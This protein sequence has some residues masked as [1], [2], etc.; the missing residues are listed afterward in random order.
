MKDVF[1]VIKDILIFTKGVLEQMNMY[2]FICLVTNHHGLLILACLGTNKWNF[3]DKL[4]TSTNVYEFN[5][6][7]SIC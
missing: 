1:I 2:N 3:Y 6:V 5:I 7:Y 4:W